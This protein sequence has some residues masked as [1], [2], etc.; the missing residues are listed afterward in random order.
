MTNTLTIGKRL[1]PA[2]HIALVE[3]YEPNENARL[4]TAR[5]F[6]ARIVL[7]NRDSIL[8]EDTVDDFASQNGFVPLPDDHVAVNP[9]VRFSVETFTP[10]E[11]FTPSK[12]YATRLKWRDLDGN[13]Q[14]K[15]LVTNP[16]T[17][18]PIAVTGEAKS[19]NDRPTP[20]P[21]KR[22]PRNGTRQSR[23]RLQTPSANA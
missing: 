9:L 3:P 13:D 8:V 5:N 10:A 16:E 11:G 22:S 14:S 20:T 18:L 23:S 7:L 6:Q 2:A 19:G 15:L 17:V 1:V 21:L 12:A 4:Q